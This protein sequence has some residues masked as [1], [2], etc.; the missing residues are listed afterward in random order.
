MNQP[1]DE[2]P[3]L[4]DAVGQGYIV[5]FIHQPVVDLA[6]G[7]EIYSWSAFGDQW[8]ERSLIYSR[9]RVVQLKKTYTLA[10][11]FLGDLVAMFLPAPF[12]AVGRKE[13]VEEINRDNV[14]K[15]VRIARPHPY[16]STLGKKGQPKTQ[17]VYQITVKNPEEKSVVHIF[18]LEKDR[19]YQ[20][21]SDYENTQTHLDLMIRSAAG[22][23]T[24]QEISQFPKEV[25]PE[26]S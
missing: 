4:A 2:S 23:D 3:E 21:L 22:P 17:Y 18:T 5:E 20:S 12:G 16:H 26:E 10:K 11:N 13:Q 1:V 15:A 14:Q 19:A 9:P 7:E 25:A 8:S 6:G 24:M